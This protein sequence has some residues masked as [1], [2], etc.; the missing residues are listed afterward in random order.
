[1]AVST[2]GRWIYDPDPALIRAGLLDSFAVAHGLGRCAAGVDYL[3]SDERADSPFLA[4]FWVMGLFP[5][6]L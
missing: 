5:L 2:L 1:M 4:A 3:T 6:D